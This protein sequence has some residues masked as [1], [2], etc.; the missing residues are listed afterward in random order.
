VLGAVLEAG[1]PLAPPPVVPVVE[2]PLAVPVWELPAFELPL[3][4]LLPVL[5][6]LGA[7]PFR[8]ELATGGFPAGTKLPMDALG[9]SAFGAPGGTLLGPSPE[10]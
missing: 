10:P 6:L 8:V 5:G 2:L 7:E 1:W 3:L 9:V 4:E